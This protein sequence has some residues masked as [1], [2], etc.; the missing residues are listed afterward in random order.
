M[1]DAYNNRGFA[2]YSMGLYEEAIKDYDKAIDIDPNYEKAKQ[3]KEEAL[4]KLSN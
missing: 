3:N 4:K 2:K 1:A